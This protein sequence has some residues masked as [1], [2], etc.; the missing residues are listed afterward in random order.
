MDPTPWLEAIGS[1]LAG[2]VIVAQGFAIFLLWRRANELSDKLVDT[3]RE[4]GGES[5]DLMASSNDAMGSLTTAVNA[6]VDRL[7]RGARS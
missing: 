3:V 7:D 2:V 1:G 5:R 4:M 6:A